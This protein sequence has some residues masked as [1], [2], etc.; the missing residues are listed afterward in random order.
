MATPFKMKGSPMARNF[1]IGSPMKQEEEKKEGEVKV[2]KTL[3]YINP[4]TGMVDQKKK[5]IYLA[6]KAKEREEIAG[7]GSAFG[8]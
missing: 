3:P 4:R 1:G 2:E 7:G 5:A 8:G 6:K